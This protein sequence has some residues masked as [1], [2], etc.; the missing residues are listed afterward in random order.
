MAVGIVV[1]R[2]DG[3]RKKLL[4]RIELRVN[5]NAHSQLPPI[6][7]LRVFLGFALSLLLCLFRFVAPLF[8]KRNNG[9]LSGL[10]L[11]RGLEAARPG[12]AAW[13]GR[14]STNCC[15]GGIEA[16]PCR[17]PSLKQVAAE[18]GRGDSTHGCEIHFFAYLVC[19]R[20][21]STLGLLPALATADQIGEAAD[22]DATARA[23]VLQLDKQKVKNGAYST[24][25][26]MRRHIEHLA[27]VAVPEA[28]FVWAE[29]YP[30]DKVR[31]PSFEVES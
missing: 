16:A 2:R 9:R 24:V 6:N 5:L 30:I 20:H 11:R 18:F 7:S 15:S 14:L 26:R 27:P 3:W 23:L 19:L 21:D 10:R 12:E 8:S 4:G 13:L 22:N 1:E 28:A 17:E 31:I 29:E 25:A